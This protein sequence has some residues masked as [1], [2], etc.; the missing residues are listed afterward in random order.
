MS[1]TDNSKEIQIHSFCFQSQRPHY[2]FNLNK[3]LCHVIII[4]SQL[5]WRKA[6]WLVMDLLLPPFQILSWPVLNICTCHYT[7][8]QQILLFNTFISDNLLTLGNQFQGRRGVPR[9]A[10]VEQA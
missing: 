9:K 7:F 2:Q 8:M 4:A 6:A 10:R 5:G 3:T 1:G